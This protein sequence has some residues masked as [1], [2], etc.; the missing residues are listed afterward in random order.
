MSLFGMG[1]AKVGDYADKALTVKKS[2]CPQNH[3]CPS[4]KA[5]P[6]GALIQKGF[7]APA[8]DRDKCVKCGKCVKT[9]PMKALVFE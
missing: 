5:C 4:V 7:G 3:S 2:R 8:V 1:A 6:K 9:C